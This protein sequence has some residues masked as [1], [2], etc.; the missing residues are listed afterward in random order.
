MRR[1][2]AWIC[3]VWLLM[4]TSVVAQEAPKKEETGAQQPKTATIEGKVLRA[5]DGTPLKKAMVMAWSMDITRQKNKSV[6]TDQDGKFLLKDVEPG[7]YSL[8][9][10]RTGYAQQSYGERRPRGAGTTLNVIAGQQVKDIVFRLVP[11]AVIAGR[12]VDEDDEP[13]YRA[14]VTAQLWH[15]MQGKRE[16]V[17]GGETTTDDLGE[18]RIS[19]LP[20]GR[21]YVS[22]SA[23]RMGIMMPGGDTPDQVFYVETYYPGVYDASR[24]AALEVKGGDEVGNINFRITPGHGVRVTGVVKGFDKESMDVRLSPKGAWHIGNEK[25][26]MANEKGEFAFG[27]VLPGAYVLQAM[28]GERDTRTSATQIIEVGDSDLQNIQMVLAERPD[29]FGRVKIEGKLTDEAGRIHVVLVPENGPQF[30]SGEP[31]TVDEKLNFKLKGYDE[32]DYR[33]TFWG[34]PEDAYVKSV[35]SGTQEALV[36]PLHISGQVKPLEIVISSNGAHVEGTVTDGEGKTFTAARVVLVPD[37]T[38]RELREFYNIGSTD[39]YGKFN[40][41]GVRPGSY[42]LYAWDKIEEG[43][44]MDP[45]FLKLYAEKGKSVKVSE[46]DRITEDLKLIEVGAE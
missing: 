30:S 44:Y 4:V 7:R 26:A 45:E 36:E 12:V 22:V 32:G 25:M 9:A 38:H 29:I 18:Y 39:Q 3:W 13:V 5:T 21:Y 46:G 40:L 35:M 28:T 20:P 41:K 1:G 27:G 23:N 6:S 2:I 8:I 24:A 17:P 43:A 10:M 16:L 42:T 19:Q 31:G 33:V 11:G 34:L 37:E 14:S 15:Y